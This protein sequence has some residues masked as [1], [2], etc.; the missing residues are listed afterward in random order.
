MPSEIEEDHSAQ[1]NPRSREQTGA[2]EGQS[3]DCEPG[4]HLVSRLASISRGDNAPRPSPSQKGKVDKFATDLSR[5]ASATWPKSPQPET[6]STPALER[7]GQ[8]HSSDRKTRGKKRKGGAASIPSTSSE[9][10]FHLRGPHVSPHPLGH[11]PLDHCQYQGSV[12][13]RSRYGHRH[14]PYSSDLQDDNETRSESAYPDPRLYVQVP[15]REPVDYFNNT[16]NDLHNQGVRV[17]NIEVGSDGLHQRLTAQLEPQTSSKVESSGSKE[18]ASISWP[19]QES[20]DL[21][22]L[23]GWPP[24]YPEMTRPGSGGPGTWPCDWIRLEFSRPQSK[25][26]GFLK[27]TDEI[28][29]RYP[30]QTYCYWFPNHVWGAG[31]DPFQAAGWSGR[32]IWNHYHPGAIEV[33]R[34][35]AILKNGKLP[36]R[37][38]NFLQ[39]RMSRRRMV[40]DT[41]APNASGPRRGA[42]RHNDSSRQ[43]RD[44]RGHSEASIWPSTRITRKTKKTSRQ[45]SQLQAETS[46]GYE[47]GHLLPSRDLELAPSVAG[48]NPTTS[49]GGY[50][51]QTTLSEPWWRGSFMTQIERVRRLRFE[52]EPGFGRYPYQAQM[53]EAERQLRRQFPMFAR[54][55]W[56]Q[57]RHGLIVLHNNLDPMNGLRDVHNIL[58]DEERRLHGLP[59]ASSATSQHINIGAFQPS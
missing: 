26:S 53:Q 14:R 44:R 29:G 48:S 31:L 54:R 10:R 11:A 20:P 1:L 45:S 58:N 46:S 40:C 43:L 8:Q 9:T 17:P 12:D 38:W 34:Q 39:Q 7:G 50:H 4:A 23:S 5:T 30:L 2:D 3:R 51:R 41:L 49:S 21:T 32:K 56:L 55:V 47:A 52:T 13:R 36:G 27:G 59:T 37:P 28:P 16:H 22:N 42:S 18:E 6:L 19:D 25:Y 33:C 35:R 57:A 15:D 24:P